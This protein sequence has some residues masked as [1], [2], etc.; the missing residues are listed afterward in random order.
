VE[1]KKRHFGALCRLVNGAENPKNNRKIAEYSR[2]SGRKGPKLIPLNDR[3]MLDE[4]LEQL[5][6]KHTFFT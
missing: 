4:L 5:I 3:E 2:Q 6:E 1:Y